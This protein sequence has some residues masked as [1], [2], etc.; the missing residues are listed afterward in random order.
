MA[1]MIL[2]TLQMPADLLERLK[3]EAKRRT[4]SMAYLVR[5]AVIA[6]LE[7]TEVTV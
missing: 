6:L 4:C 1:N 5:E 3:A 7:K 2:I